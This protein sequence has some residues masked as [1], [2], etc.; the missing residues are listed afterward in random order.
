V[1]K[2]HATCGKF[3]FIKD[4]E[5]VEHAAYQAAIGCPMRV[6]YCTKCSAYHCTRIEKERRVP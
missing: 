6:Y 4:Y 3:R 1:K 2:R 5:A